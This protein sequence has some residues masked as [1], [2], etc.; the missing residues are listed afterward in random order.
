[1]REP[2][3]F[4]PEPAAAPWIVSGAMAMC[5]GARARGRLKNEC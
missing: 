1:L 2:P 5:A 4:G 3:V